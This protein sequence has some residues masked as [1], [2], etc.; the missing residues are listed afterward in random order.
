MV[1][2]IKSGGKQRPPPKHLKQLTQ[3]ITKGLE[4]K[5]KKGG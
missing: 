1:W 3:N 4:I 2:V 5:I